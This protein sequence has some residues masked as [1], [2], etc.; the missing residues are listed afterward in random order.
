VVKVKLKRGCNIVEKEKSFKELGYDLAENSTSKI[1]YVKYFG[2]SS[3]PKHK[4]SSQKIIFNHKNKSVVINVRNE[5]GNLVN[6]DICVDTVKAICQAM[7][8]F[9]LVK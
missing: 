3:L 2:D 8:R 6:Y 9:W 4:R 5:K 7:K 1:V